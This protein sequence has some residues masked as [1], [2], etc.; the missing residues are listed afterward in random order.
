MNTEIKIKNRNLFNKKA[1]KIS[2]IS[3]NK[4]SYGALDDYYR[5]TFELKDGFNILF[6]PRHIGRGIEFYWSDNLNKELILR[7]NS[8]ST[9]Y[10]IEMLYDVVRNVTSVWNER[11]FYENDEFVRVSDIANLYQRQVEYN[12]KLISNIYKINMKTIFGAIFPIEIDNDTLKGFV[13]NYDGYTKYLHNLQS[14]NA[15]Y[16]SP[17]IFPYKENEYYGNYVVSLDIDT[18]FPIKA[19]D[20]ILFTNKQIKCSLFIVTIASAKEKEIYATM[21]FDEFVNKIDINSYAK[22]DSTHI[23]LKGLTKEKITELINSH[24]TKVNID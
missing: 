6:N 10:D 2:D 11:S 3:L 5:N 15:H 8:L 13:N 9:R 4:Y 14:V 23:L 21:Y 20:P 17:L 24:Y 1:L 19:S 12:K 18:I 16:A 7:I 22:F